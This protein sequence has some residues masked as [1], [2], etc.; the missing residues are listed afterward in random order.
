[1]LPDEWRDPIHRVYTDTLMIFMERTCADLSVD[2]GEPS[3][4]GRHTDDLFPYLA[5]GQD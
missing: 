3:A 2:A 4:A 1:R 5:C